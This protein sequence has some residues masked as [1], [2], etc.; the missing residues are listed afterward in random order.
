M[1][2]V[3]DNNCLEFR[4]LNTCNENKYTGCQPAKNKNQGSVEHLGEILFVTI[5]FAIQ[6][7]GT[8]KE[9]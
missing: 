7:T 9:S 2:Q 5:I 6:S 4:T 3:S 8:L 1:C